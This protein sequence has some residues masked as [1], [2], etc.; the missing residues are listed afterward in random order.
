MQKPVAALGGGLSQK[1]PGAA[2]PAGRASHF[3]LLLGAEYQ[4]L[5][6]LLS[7]AV[8]PPGGRA[9]LAMQNACG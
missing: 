9:P 7:K 1:Q 5:L 2:P 3:T 6:V 8:R 4:C